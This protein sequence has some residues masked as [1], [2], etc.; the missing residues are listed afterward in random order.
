MQSFGHKMFIY[1]N[2]TGAY[3]Q[4]TNL[5]KVDKEQALIQKMSWR[6]LNMESFGHKMIIW[7]QNDHLV[8]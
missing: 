1:Q 2:F 6:P 3:N 8:T 4:K 5:G 7:S